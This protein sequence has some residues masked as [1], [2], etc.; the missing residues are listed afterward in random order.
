MVREQKC[1]RKI[2]RKRGENRPDGAQAS[3]GGADDDHFEWTLRGLE[4]GGR[5]LQHHACASVPQRRSV[6]QQ[7]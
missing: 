1:A 3:R 4:P 5:M 7:T 6:R 2:S